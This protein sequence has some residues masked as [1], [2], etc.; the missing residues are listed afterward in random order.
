MSN[1]FQELQSVVPGKNGQVIDSHRLLVVDDD[2][3]VRQALSVVLSSCGYVCDQ[4]SSAHEALEYLKKQTYTC[5]LTDLIMPEKSG[6]EL[7]RDI[8]TSYPDIAVILVSGQNDTGLVRKALKNGAYDYVVKP[9]TAGEILTTVYGA[10]KKRENYLREQN[11]KQNLREKIEVGQMQYILFK[12]I[13]ESTIDGIMITDLENR[14]ISVN[15]AYERLTGFM[16]EELIGSTPSIFAR[17]GQPGD[18]VREIFRSLTL[19]GSWFGEVID[20]RKDGSQWSAHITITRVKDS[21]GKAFADVFIVR[22]ISDKKHMENQ[23]IERVQELHSAQDAAI[24]GFAK[25]AECRDAG[26]GFHLERMRKYCKVL[27]EDLAHLPKYRSEIDDAYIERLYKSSPLHD[28]GKVGI[29]D[30][31]LLKA[32]KLTPEEYE[33]MKKHSKIGGDVLKSAE[34]RLP[35]KSFLTLGREI[36]YHHH[37]KFDGTGYPDGLSGEAIPLSARIVALADAYDALTSKRVYK[38]I[39]DPE[40]SKRRIVIDRG[41]H[42]DPDVVDAFLRKENEFLNILSEFSR[43]E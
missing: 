40:E 21:R 15:P 24:F 2:P 33:T 16:H 12:D 28:V 18:K 14:I 6:I 11:D 3:A 1:E 27:A 38:D 20:D 36:A 43:D 34:S 17:D 39:V 41:R 37:E 30:N 25:L 9:A 42:F 23:L 10:L 22:D 29:S 32:G 35:G 26:L 13:V 31:I 4:A 19:K 5:V 7:L 8:V